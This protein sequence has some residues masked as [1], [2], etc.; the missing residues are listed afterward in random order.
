M[1]TDQL[2]MFLTVAREGN[3]SRAAEKLF[4][5]QP[6]VSQSIKLLEQEL[7]EKLFLRLGRKTA[8]TKAGQIVQ[9]HALKVFEAMDQARNRIDALKKLKYGE[10][11][12]SA[13]DTTACY[14]L[15]DVLRSFNQTYPGVEIRIYNR[16]SPEA[17]RQVAERESDIGIVTLPVDHPELASQA[18]VVREDVVICAP[19]HRLASR[20]RATL[21]E[22]TPYP[23]ILLDRGSNTRHY[24][25]ERLEGLDVR[26]NIAMEL[27]SIEVIK[28]MVQMD[29]GISFVPA[30]SIIDEIERGELSKLRVFKKSE[31]RQLGVVYSAKSFLPLAA[32]VFVQMLE[33]IVSPY[34]ML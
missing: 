17:S 24:I 34:K 6:A 16:P 13:S 19:G 31:C 22:L 10:L 12:V 7:G 32:K 15:P 18:L 26:P 2:H 20:K 3:F 9:E 33:D 5:T 8:L 1:N 29:F 14:I 4:L 21:E 25:D 27:G 23:L 30:V 11:T 28:K